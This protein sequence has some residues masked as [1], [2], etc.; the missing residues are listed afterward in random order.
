MPSLPTTGH[1]LHERIREHI[2]RIPELA[3][4]LEQHPVP[5]AFGPRFEAEVAF[6]TGTLLP[7]V[8]V[9][10]DTLYPELE[11]L[12][13]NRHSMAPMRRE[14]KELARLIEAMEG[15][16]KALRA[17]HM[18]MTEAMGLRRV[19]FR[20]YA[21]VKVHLGEEQEYL[22]VLERNLSPEEQEALGKRIEHAVAHPL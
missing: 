6:I 3:D 5:E 10:E 17:G 16:L 15:Y 20:F 22:R 19:L 21:V 9:V 13:Q 14:H 2:D 4:M 8:A 12:M 11:R 18:G 1:E 7:H